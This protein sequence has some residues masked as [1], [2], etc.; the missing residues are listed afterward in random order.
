VSV[1]R[2]LSQQGIEI[3]SVSSGALV[4]DAQTMIG[5]TAASSLAIGSDPISAAQRVVSL[6]QSTGQ[7]P[8]ETGNI[9][10]Q[11]TD[12]DNSSLC[13]RMC[14]GN[15]HCA[16]DKTCG[17][18]SGQGICGSKSGCKLPIPSTPSN[19]NTSRDLEMLILVDVGEPATR[20]TS[21]RTASELGLN[22]STG[23][24]G[25]IQFAAPTNISAS[26]FPISN[27]ALS[28]LGCVSDCASI[29]TGG[30]ASALDQAGKLLNQSING[31]SKDNNT[32]PLQVVVIISSQVR[33]SITASDYD[34]APVKAARSLWS[35]GIQVFSLV[36]AQLCTYNAEG[37]SESYGE[38]DGLKFHF[39]SPPHLI[40]FFCFCFCFCF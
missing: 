16:A 40:V 3:V 10:L 35:D 8:V 11:R 5:T 31:P 28:S 18:C 1:S 30:L 19:T 32:G 37:F 24:I 9:A 12:D 39:C 36:S 26:N 33:A 25:V 7:S 27:S 23:K 4:S 21:L 6:L 20:L 22:F 34:A 29:G 38:C 17:L 15:L 14:A 2:E 13:G